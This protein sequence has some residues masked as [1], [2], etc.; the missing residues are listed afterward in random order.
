MKRSG[1]LESEGG[2]RRNWAHARRSF[3]KRKKPQQGLVLVGSS[4]LSSSRADAAGFGGGSGSKELASFSDMASLSYSDSGALS[5]EPQIN[6][7]IRVE[8]LDC[9]N[10]LL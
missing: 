1:E 2:S 4:L 10:W 6:S 8:R 9:K 5:E 3:F 7:Y